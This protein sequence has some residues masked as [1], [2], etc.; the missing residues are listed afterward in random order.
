MPLV[1]SSAMFRRRS[2]VR[3]CILPGAD[4]A[5]RSTS[6]SEPRAQYSA[7]RLD[8]VAAVG[9]LQ[10]S[11][12][13]AATCT[14]AAS[15]AAVPMLGQ[16]QQR[17]AQAQQPHWVGC[18]HS[19]VIMAGGQVLTPMNCGSRGMGERKGWGMAGCVMRAG[20]RHC[21]GLLAGADSRELRQ[22]RRRGLGH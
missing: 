22:R 16:A 10:A 8:W 4:L 18:Q 19:P 6:A 13:V 14:P 17:Q 12:A 11:L 1:A 2:H 9:V 20:I 7:V 21:R 5:A 15:S 3:C